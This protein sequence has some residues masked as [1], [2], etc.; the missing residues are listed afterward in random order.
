MDKF[1][2]E[3]QNT[4]DESVHTLLKDLIIQYEL[5]YAVFEKK[6]VHRKTGTTFRFKGFREHGSVNIKGLEGVD[7]LWIDEAE[8]ITKNTLAWLN[9]RIVEE[10]G[11]GEW[12]F[13]FNVAPSD[14][15]RRELVNE[16]E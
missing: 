11:D 3:I 14:R 2:Q 7:I 9:Q 8:A 12:R 1:I 10:N 5:D 4:I 15:V 13:N 6:I 16:L